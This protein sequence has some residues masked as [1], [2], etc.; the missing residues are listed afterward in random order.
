MMAAMHRWLLVLLV[1]LLPLRGWVGEA[2]AGQML[3][4]QLAIAA[5]VQAPAPHHGAKAHEDCMGH[6]AADATGDAAADSPNSPD[7]PTCASCQVCSAVAIAPVTR[8]TPSAGFSQPPP[9]SIE[10]A[11]ASAERVNAFK[12]PIS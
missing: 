3:Q 10:R 8:G 11:H 4:Q 9:A 7:C 5:A 2:M 12:P 6:Q 1:A